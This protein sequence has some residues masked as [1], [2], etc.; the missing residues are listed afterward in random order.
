MNH[1]N[2]NLMLLL[3]DSIWHHFSCILEVSPEFKGSA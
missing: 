2:C 3:R 1:A